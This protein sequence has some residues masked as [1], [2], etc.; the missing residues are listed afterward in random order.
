[1]TY[2][3]GSS[4][5]TVLVGGKSS[6]LMQMTGLSSMLMLMYLDSKLIVRTWLLFRSHLGQCRLVS[7]MQIH[8]SSPRGES[9]SLHRRLLHCGLDSLLFMARL[10][11]AAFVLLSD[12][13]ITTTPSIGSHHF[14]LLC[15]SHSFGPRLLAS[16]LIS[17][18]SI[19]SL[20]L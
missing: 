4:K 14:L 5:E 6:A 1:M 17:R 11:F 12:I 19:Q 9:C 18:S 16:Q 7:P 10:V 15:D 20:Q 3:S 2:L 13:A 8:F